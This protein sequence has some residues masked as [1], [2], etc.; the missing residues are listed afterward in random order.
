MTRRLSHRYLV[1]ALLLAT[2]V[3]HYTVTMQQEQ[4]PSPNEP[5]SRYLTCVVDDTQYSPKP[6][7]VAIWWIQSCS[8]FTD[9]VQIPVRMLVRFDVF[10]KPVTLESLYDNGELA[11]TLPSVLIYSLGLPVPQIT[12]CSLRDLLSSRALQYP[13]TLFL[14]EAYT[15][16]TE[17]YTVA[18]HTGTFKAGEE[19]I[20]HLLS[21]YTL[22]GGE[23]SRMWRQRTVLRSLLDRVHQLPPGWEWLRL[24]QKRKV[25]FH[26]PPCTRP[27]GWK[28][29]LE[30]DYLFL[31]PGGFSAKALELR[32]RDARF[33]TRVSL[34]FDMDV[35]PPV[36]QQIVEQVFNEGYSVSIAIG[37]QQCE[38]SFDLPDEVGRVT[39]RLQHI[40]SQHKLTVEPFLRNRTL[41]LTIHKEGG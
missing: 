35:A 26:V 2:L 17:T 28:G 13:V 11:R 9:V 5:L 39:R 22:F 41:I 38:Q 14:D 36:R 25:Q 31:V 40:L 19:E 32:K 1:A 12:F 4:S 27:V 29:G 8:Q 34:C 20:R 30:G 3:A 37:N 7:L 15:V 23:W 16:F 10:S 33:L 24:L 21:G 18:F 6:K